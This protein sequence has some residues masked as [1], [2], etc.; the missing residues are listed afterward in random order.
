MCL[1][2]L[3]KNTFQLYPNPSKT[4]ITLQ[5]KSNLGFQNIRYCIYDVLGNQIDEGKITR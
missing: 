5:S 2:T 4:Y 3:K 1:I